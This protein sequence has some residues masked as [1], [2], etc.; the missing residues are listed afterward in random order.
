MHRA[1]VSAEKLAKTG[2]KL[3]PVAIEGRTIARTFW[4]RAWC[5]NLEAYSDYEN[6]LPRGRSYLSNGLVIDLKIR[7]GQV[8]AKV[9][10]SDL[11]RVDIKVRPVE[12][13]Q[14]SGIQRACAGQIDSLVELLSGKLSSGVMQAL[15]RQDGGLFPKPAEIDLDCSCPDWAEMCKHVAAT[16]YGIGARL[17]QAPELLFTLRQVDHMDLVGHA[18]SRVVATTVGKGKRDAALAG[19][20]LSALFGIDIEQRPGAPVAAG[21]VVAASRSPARRGR[22]TGARSPG[23]PRAV[24]RNASE[25]SALASTAPEGQRALRARFRIGSRITTADL[26][27]LSIPRSTFQNWVTEGVL[28]RTATRGVYVVTPATSARVER[29]LAAARPA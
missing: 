13:R 12:P 28:E 16:L 17:D 27:A 25:A 11:Y 5:E 7:P 6:R 19:E 20:D 24:A 26:L 14:W 29:A 1:R 23:E 2:E 3:E 18:G 9:C 22:P 4:G 8:A 15:C 21:P 10:G